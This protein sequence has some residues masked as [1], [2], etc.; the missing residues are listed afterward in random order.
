VAE[1]FPQIVST[2]F[3][4]HLLWIEAECGR[5]RTRVW[6]HLGE[7]LKGTP[8]AVLFGFERERVLFYLSSCILIQPPKPYEKAERSVAK[9][10]FRNGRSQSKSTQARH[11]EQTGE[12]P[13]LW[14]MTLTK[15]S[16]SL[17]LLTSILTF[18]MLSISTLKE[19]VWKRNRLKTT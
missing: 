16:F 10:G 14:Q 1:T 6:P 3:S 5:F 4:G 13:V 11:D 15:R 9:P 18:S 19:G 7:P 17:I 12:K 2:R 8:P